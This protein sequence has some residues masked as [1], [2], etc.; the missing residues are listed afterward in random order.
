MTTDVFKRIDWT[1]PQLG[2][3]IV[4]LHAPI[5]RA[6]IDARRALVAQLPSEL[7]QALYAVIDLQQDA[8][9]LD[10]VLHVVRRH[11][12]ADRAAQHLDQALA[13]KL[14]RAQAQAAAHQRIIEDLQRQNRNLRSH[15]AALLTSAGKREAGRNL[16]AENARLTAESETL[17][18]ELAQLREQLRSGP[19][20]RTIDSAVRDARTQENI[21]YN[22]LERH[23]RDLQTELEIT[24]GAPAG[25]ALIAAAP[26]PAPRVRRPRDQVVT[27]APFGVEAVARDVED[28]VR[29]Q[30]RCSKV[31]VSAAFPHARPY[32]S[33]VY[34]H[35]HASRRVHVDGYTLKPWPHPIKE[36]R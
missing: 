26:T 22:R 17:R 12:R 4:A 32:L 21:R 19:P 29:R 28:Y 10:G 16:V 2:D 7:H 30:G 1:D 34:R 20:K 9:R 13:P 15:N 35:L 3:Q 23:A 33:A 31:D 11:E 5:K 24:R 27:D 36:D 18:A 14:A 6:A 25:L 8:E